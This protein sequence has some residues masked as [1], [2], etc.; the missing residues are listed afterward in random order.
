MAVFVC[1]SIT[2]VFS[3]KFSLTKHVAELIIKILV[4]LYCDE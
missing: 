3:C 4:L 1:C 2:P